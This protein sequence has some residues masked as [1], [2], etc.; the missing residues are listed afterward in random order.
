[1]ANKRIERKDIV[2]GDAISSIT[3]ELIKLEAELIK[4]IKGFESLIKINPLKTAKDFD[5]FTKD[6][7]GANASLKALTATQKKLKESTREEGVELAA[8]RIQLQEQ[9]KLNKQLAKEKLGLVSAYEK[10]T[11]TL[12]SLRKNYKNVAIELGVNSKEAKKL[13]IEVSKL[14][15]KLKNVDKSAGQSQRN[16]GNYGSAWNRAG[17]ALRNFAGALGITAG[18]MGLV[19]V[20]SNSVKIA[21]DFE[22]GN[23][24]LAA[25]LGKTSSNI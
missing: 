8:V 1:M 4:I 17:G 18:L 14:D 6:T 22:Q 13:Q 10:E 19:R 20:L 23:A 2:A 11:R 16:V 24:N 9:N 3:T 5:K 21:K 12:I 15:R 25:V 7:Q